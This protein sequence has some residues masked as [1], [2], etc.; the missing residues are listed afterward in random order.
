MKP[1]LIHTAGP[2]GQVCGL[3]SAARPC[4]RLAKGGDAEDRS[5]Q[6]DNEAVNEDSGRAGTFERHFGG[7]M[8]RAGLAIRID[9]DTQV[10]GSLGITG[11]QVG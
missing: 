8:D 1:V 9:I 3:Y 10:T 5:S 4:G 2:A 7:R 11:D 6:R